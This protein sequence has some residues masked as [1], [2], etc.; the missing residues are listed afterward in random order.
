MVVEMPEPHASGVRTGRVWITAGA[1][2]ICATVIPLAFMSASPRSP[3]AW[4]GTVLFASALVL[5]AVGYRGVGRITRGQEY[6]TVGLFVL[7]AW[8]VVAAIVAPIVHETSDLE[9]IRTFAYVS[10]AIQIA[11]ASTAVVAIG[12]AAV[13]PA[14]WNWAPAWTLAARGCAAVL[15]QLPNQSGTE[16][17]P[18]LIDAMQR[19]DSLA[20]LICP[21]F[22]GVLAIVLGARAGRDGATVVF[23]GPSDESER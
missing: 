3:V 21:L 1:L 15:T 13:L 19:L 6:G 9:G 10:F 20:G 16:D 4:T 12:R 18:A 7:A 11:A 14:P 22:L 8:L 23:T 17:F 2:L 5:L